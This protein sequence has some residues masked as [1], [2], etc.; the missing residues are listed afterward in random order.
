MKIC[1][2]LLYVYYH[3]SC[4]GEVCILLSIIKMGAG[5]NRETAAI[6]KPLCIQQLKY[7][8]FY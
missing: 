8:T 3:N 6:L 5:W 4:D 7:T 1:F 2:P